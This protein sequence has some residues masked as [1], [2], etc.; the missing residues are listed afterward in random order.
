MAALKKQGKWLTSRRVR[1][2]KRLLLATASLPVLQT[3]GCFPDLLGALNFELQSLVNTT[4]INAANTVIQN[5]LG[6]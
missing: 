6:L 4:L 2:L 3:T 1:L 5:V